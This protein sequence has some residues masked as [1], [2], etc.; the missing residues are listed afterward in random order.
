M[1]RTL[2]LVALA[3][4]PLVAQ[5]RFPRNHITA[6][7]GSGIPGQDLKGNFEPS[8]GFGFN[9]AY[10]FHRNFQADAGVD[11]TIQAA[12]IEDYIYTSFGARRIR[13]YQL[14]VPMGGRVVLPFAGDRWE[15]FAGGGGA[16]VR[17]YEAVS[18]PSTWI[19]IDCP[20]C[21]ARHGFG[22]YGLTGVRYQPSRWRGFWF[23]GSVRVLRVTTDGEPFGSLVIRPSRDR[24][25]TPMM[26]FGFRF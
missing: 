9:Y 21:A 12:R 8:F 23:G 22:Y 13:D 7:I 25:V 3:A 15:F 17:Y 11:F 24:W 5:S 19:H 10:R 6:G 14:F 16:Y 4:A 18:Q 2:L 26:E 20:Y 1:K